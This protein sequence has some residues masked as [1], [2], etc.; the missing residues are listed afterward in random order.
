MST[1]VCHSLFLGRYLTI[2]VGCVLLTLTILKRQ[3]GK[4]RLSNEVLL[5]YQRQLLQLLLIFSIYLV[6]GLEIAAFQRGKFVG[7]KY[8]V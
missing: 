4:L 8:A 7:L 6:T 2:Y 3:Q 5:L 1:L